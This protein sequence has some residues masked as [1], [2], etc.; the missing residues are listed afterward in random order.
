MAIKCQKLSQKYL[1]MTLHMNSRS[2]EETD[3]KA[4]T[5]AADVSIIL[6]LL[7]DLLRA[8]LFYLINIWLLRLQGCM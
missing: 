6:Q 4:L 5:A 8:T 2:E 3:Q 7:Q 1:N